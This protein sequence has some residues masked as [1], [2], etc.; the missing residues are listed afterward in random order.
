VAKITR[1]RLAR[2]TKLSPDHVT[3][4]LSAAATELEDINIDRSQMQAPMA[5]FC[6]NLSLPYLGSE[7]PSGTI[8]VPF[9][10]PPLQ[11]NFSAQSIGGGLY[12]P[13]YS[14]GTPQT[15]LKSVSFSF[16]QRAEPAAIVSHLWNESGTTG[17]GL[18]GYSSEQ[19]KLSFEDAERLDINLSIHSKDAHI[20]GDTYPYKT[21]TTIWSGVIPASALMGASLRANPFIQTDIDI[22]VNPYKTY[23]FKV[24]CPG[25][26]DSGA[27]RSLCLPAVEVSMKFVCELMSRDTGSSIQNI[28]RRTGAGDT[29]WG[30]KT[31]PTV[32]ITAPASGTA[33][34]SDSSDGVGYN[35]TAIDDEFREKLD[36]GYDR[37][38]DAPPTEVVKHDAAYDV[39]AVPLFQNSAHGGVGANPTYLATMPYVGTRASM[40]NGAGIFDRRLIPVHHSY[41]V[42]HMVLAWNWTPWNILNGR[43]PIDAGVIPA[44]NQDAW[45]VAPS[46][47]IQ[48]K[49]GVGIG[50]GDASDEFGYDQLGTITL[51]DPNNYGGGGITAPDGWGAGVTLIDRITSTPNPPFQ[52]IEVGGVAGVKHKWNWE[53]HS[54]PID[55]TG[56]AQP[57]YYAQGHPA[58]IGPGWTNTKTRSNLDSVTASTKGAEQWIEVRANLFPTDAGK[59]L[60]ESA[61]PFPVSGPTGDIADRP[62][63]LVG[64]GGCY[65]Y[66]ICKKSLTR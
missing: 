34:E 41:S 21:I 42:H 39:I 56:S 36:G 33:I 62:S 32:A 12:N 51:T 20:F 7:V 57:G 52:A 9:V 54:I 22:T 5:P 1:K 53:L 50:T 26:I 4:P 49:V 6:V 27:D 40:T 17:S 31:G 23:F 18:Y 66:L 65:V 29:K 14:P 2:G 60:D 19:G 46:A 44:N 28:P 45:Q 38:A 15:K 47:G 48:L 11:E 43:D 30:A 64:Y 63:I 8:T 61:L 58:F 13:L 25:L 10:L 3:A 37:Y 35:I 16:D 24:E 59:S 55:P